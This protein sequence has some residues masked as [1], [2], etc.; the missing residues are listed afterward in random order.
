MKKLFLLTLFIA[1]LCFGQNA[2]RF[3]PDFFLITDRDPGVC[4]FGSFYLREDTGVF[5]KCGPLGVLIPIATSS[6][7]T[8]TGTSTFTGG[9]T[10]PNGS[11]NISFGNNNT[12]VQTLVNPSSVNN[13]QINLLSTGV[14][15][16][17]NIG[18]ANTAVTS[19]QKNASST[20]LIHDF[21]FADVSVASVNKTGIYSKY[22][23][24]ATAGNGLGSIVA[25]AN[26]T[27]QGASIGSTLLYT[28]TATSG[29]LYLPICY[30]VETVADAVSST[31][32]ACNFVYTD[33]DL[34]ATATVTV[35]ATSTGNVVGQLGPIG[36]RVV[37]NAKASTA[38]NYST[39]S[40]ASNTP[41]VMKYAVHLALVR[42]GN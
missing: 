7:G 37:I 20:G 28:T 19:D 38:V 9:I 36:T 39:T 31:L 4:N 41:G 12:F 24:E 2:R 26:A 16:F 6:G 35:V 30:T 29:G 33:P 11:G 14:V 17:R 21:Q 32:P 3:S 8:F 42:I 1:S 22:A 18:D 40:Y 23:G 34:N 5:S 13:A 27:A 10:V 25:T 15:M